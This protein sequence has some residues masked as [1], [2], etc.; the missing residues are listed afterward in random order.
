[1]TESSDLPAEVRR[2]DEEDE[3][4]VASQLSDLRGNP[5]AAP[6]ANL[7][8]EVRD[9]D[10]EDGLRVASQLSDLRGDDNG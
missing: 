7:A 8:A 5:Q 10:E 1:M 9:E 2:Q 3:L 4:R 6:A